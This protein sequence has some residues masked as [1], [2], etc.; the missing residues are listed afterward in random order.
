M[1]ISIIKTAKKSPRKSSLG[2]FASLP[3]G[4]LNSWGFITVILFNMTVL[5]AIRQKRLKT[6]LL[7]VTLNCSLRGQEIRQIWTLLKTAGCSWSEKLQWETYIIE[8]TETCNYNCLQLL[9]NT[10]RNSVY[11]CLR[12]LHWSSL[13]RVYTPNIRHE[14]VRQWLR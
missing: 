7:R 12:G 1:D 5:R 3:D 10:A 8:G 2:I 14:T 6:G 9:E 11:R 13:T 4:Y